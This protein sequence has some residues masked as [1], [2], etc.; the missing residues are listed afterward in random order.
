MTLALTI[1]VSIIISF[2]V[3]IG[4]K[5][6]MGIIVAILFFLT[7]VILM[8]RKG[9]EGANKSL[10]YLIIFTIP[11]PCFIQFLGRDALTITT[12]GIFFLFAIMSF[13]CLLRRERVIFDPR[14][15]FVIP[16]LIF[17]NLTLSL[18]LNPEFFARALRYYVANTSGIALYF[19]IITTLK[20]N[21]EIVFIIKIILFTLILQSLV[22]L[23]Q[24]KFP[25]IARVITAPFGER[26]A[27]GYAPIRELGIVRANGVV[28][29]YELLSEMFLI[30][31]VLSIGLIYQLKKYV[32]V[33]PLF[34]Y[35]AGIIFTKTRSS[36]LLFA[37]ALASIFI[38][39]NLAGKDYRRTS[40]KIV[41]SL[42]CAGIVLGFIFRGQ[43]ND[44]V[45]RAGAYFGSRNLMSAEAIN[46]KEVWGAGVRF[47][48]KNPTIFGK[49]IYDYDFTVGE[50][51]FHSPYLTILCKIGIFGLIIHFIFWLKM[52]QKAGY[53]LAVRT[54]VENWYLLFF[55]LIAVIL[56]L[57][58][59]TKIEYLR[60]SH[61][62]QFAWLIYA[63]LV[64]SLNQNRK[65]DEN[66]VV[67]QA[68]V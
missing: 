44:F 52:L 55:L 18:I 67:P 51:S 64:A 46:R 30:G 45:Q 42:V 39:L 2:L 26:I 57:I 36:M 7:S 35:L 15:A 41:L 47:F 53:S 27:T 59:E 37:L 24:L 33:F 50:G 56:M 4:S 5:A 32:Y 40:M 65:N 12:L 10:L 62:I 49:G 17:A 21:S 68:S 11:F 1:F 63:L 60:Y 28:G 34:I 22:S 6:A 38:G 48:L 20:K 23:L 66:I 19:I 3:L 14:F 58:D 9:D 61:T 29:D 16:I 31:M 25:E 8:Q 13:N 54:K 43:V